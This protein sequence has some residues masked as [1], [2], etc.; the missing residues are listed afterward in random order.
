MKGVPAGLARGSRGRD[1]PEG[2]PSAV[3]SPARLSIAPSWETRPR[4]AAAAA[5]LLHAD[6][7]NS[8][9]AVKQPNSPASLPADDP[10]THALSFS[11]FLSSLLAPISLRHTL[12]LA[13]AV[14]T[15]A[16]ARGPKLKRRAAR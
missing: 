14:S 12:A 8:S 15:P 3:G 2:S 1:G 16:A 9:P 13:V 7:R 6:V 4:D 11:L 5:R 10:H